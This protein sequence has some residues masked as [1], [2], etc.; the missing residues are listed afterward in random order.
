MGRRRKALVALALL[1]P[2]V[3]AFVIVRRS[4]VTRPASVVIAEVM[5]SNAATI[6]DEDGESADWIE[7]WNRS[8]ETVDLYGWHLTA[9]GGHSENHTDSWELPRVKL[10]PNERLVIFAS[11]KSEQHRLHTNF[12]L[13]ADGE[14]LGLRDAQGQTLDEY[15][16]PALGADVSYGLGSDG[17][18]GVLETPTPGLPNTATKP[19]AAAKPVLSRAG[20]YIDGPLSLTAS[21]ATS[22]AQLWYTVDGSTPSTENGK[23]YSG[24]ISIGSTTTLRM[25]ATRQG[26]SDSPVASAT[27]LVLTEVLAQ[28]GTP[29]G[30]STEPVNGQVYQFGLDQ[31]Y[32]SRHLTQVGNALLAAPTLS[33]TTDLDNL[34][35]EASGIYSNP[36]EQGLAWERPASIELIDG[37]SGFQINGGVR[38]KGGYSRQ[39]ANPKHSFRLTFALA[40]EGPLNY[41][42]FG[43]DGVQTFESLDLRTEQNY[44]WQ[45]QDPTTGAN[46]RNTMIRDQFLRDSQA[47][48][49]DPSTRSRWVHLFLNG[50]YW[51]LYMLRNNITAEHAAQLW[52]GSEHDYDIITSAADFGYEVEDGTDDEWSEM[53]SAISDGFLTDDEFKMIADR[54]D[55][56]DLADFILVN[57]C[58]GNIDSSPS[59]F[60]SEL[61]ANNWQ[62]VGGEGQPFRFFLDDGEHTLGAWDHSVAVDR[63]RIFPTL[64]QNVH[65]N[66]HNFNPG[67]LH[68][69]LLTRPQYREIFR[70]RAATL[71]APDGAL[72]AEASLSRWKQLRET[73]DPLIEAEAARWG[74]GNERELGRAQW[75]AEV[76]WVQDIWF[77]RRTEIVRK[78]LIAQQ[79]LDPES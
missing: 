35:G 1:V 39:L 22:G 66:A 51:G 18:T 42:V 65:W 73:I 64:A 58:T 13:S 61:L 52:G 46:R 37:D 36:G 45:T 4:Q 76:D 41:P 2:S 8:A 31:Q 9:G 50:Q 75:E 28:S 3:V 70:D 11:D 74:Y 16:T 7:L 49:G 10:D 47:A 68:Q 63:T 54:T 67:W 62:A 34:I 15:N 19:A 32:I 17:K 14:Y 71:L 6:T 12:R 69:V 23:S 60:L 26:L 56:A 25:V 79:L 59:W 38:L 72:A 57:I 24:P 21:S 30:W 78:Q 55:L 5:T 44:G 43:L 20:G 77:P 33:I 27:F 53:W 40:N 29:D 48:V